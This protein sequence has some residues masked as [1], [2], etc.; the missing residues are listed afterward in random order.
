MNKIIKSF[1]LLGEVSALLIGL[2]TM[3]NKNSKEIIIPIHDEL[4]T[5]PIYDGSP[6]TVSEVKT[7]DNGKT[8]LYVDNKPFTMIGAQIRVDALMNTD[9]MSIEDLEPFF[10]ASKDLNVTTVQIPLEWKDIEIEENTWDF[11]YIAK[12]LEYTNKYDLKCEFLWFG[13]NMCGDTHSFTVP[14][15]ILKDGKTYPKLDASRTGEYWSY[16]GIQWFMDFDN[17]NLIEKESRAITKC[18]DYVYEYD[19]THEGKK[20]LIGFQVLNEPDIFIR[21]RLLDKEVISRNTLAQMSYEEAWGKVLTA[22]DAYGKA[23][24]NSKYKVYTRVNLA[25]STG[26]D[27]YGDYAY[28]IWNGSSVKVPPEWAKKIFELE[29]I[30]SIGD[31]SY[32]STVADIKAISYMYGNNLPGNFSHIAENAGSYTNTSSLIIS[33]LSQGAGYNIYDLA[34]PPFYI[35]HGSASVDQGIYRYIDGE[36]VPHE[37]KD[38]VKNIITG[39]RNAGTLVASFDPG[40]FVGLNINGNTPLNDVNQTIRTNKLTI[41]FKTSNKG[42]GFAVNSSSELL[43]YV[44]EDSTISLSNC[45]VSSVMTGYYINDEFTKLTDE[46]TSINNVLIKKNTLYRFVLSSTSSLS[47]NAWNYIG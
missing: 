14:E 15:Y 6:I 39:L 20:P 23:A 28:G 17:P 38:E 22:I 46:S 2:S 3:S 44:S 35:S 13:T 10:K 41:N 42:F 18:L 9:K 47:S 37:H 36:L 26:K 32:T 43:V 27:N 40:D 21:F 19:S 12:I 16:Y 1:L 5:A 30:D 11:N 33:A 25:A 24:K 7:L 4:K 45:S 34:T 8:V 31:D 29:G